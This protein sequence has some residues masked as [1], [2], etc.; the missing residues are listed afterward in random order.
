MGVLAHRNERRYRYIYTRLNADVSLTAK[1]L[2]AIDR[3][4]ESPS[5]ADVMPTVLG[6]VLRAADSYPFHR[7]RLD[8]RFMLPR[9]LRVVPAE[10]RHEFEERREDLQFATELSGALILASVV[11]FAFLYDDGAWLLLPLGCLV[12]A[13]AAYRNAIAAAVSYGE[14][15]RVV[16]DLYRHLLYE[17]LRLPPPRSLEDERALA[18]SI[19]MEFRFGYVL[20]PKRPYGRMPDSPQG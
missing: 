4:G 12:L 14:V 8:T 16:F 3:L 10:A 6:T 19:R 2:E 17:A 15:L 1:E 9:L 5:A 20:D 13:W 11:T 18:E 7:Y